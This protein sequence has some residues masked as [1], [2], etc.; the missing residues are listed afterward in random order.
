MIVVGLDREFFD[1]QRGVPL[2]CSHSLE[3]CSSIGTDNSV[4]MKNVM[5]ASRCKRHGIDR[6]GQ[7]MTRCGERKTR[8]ACA[9]T[10]SSDTFLPS[11]NRFQN[12]VSN[13]RSGIS[14]FGKPVL[15]TSNCLDTVI[16]YSEPNDYVVEGQPGA[17]G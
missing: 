7:P 16:D 4:S 6:E 12:Q 3:L 5:V 1:F 13:S 15:E 2:S 9:K 14:T 11:K 8:I 17:P 10:I